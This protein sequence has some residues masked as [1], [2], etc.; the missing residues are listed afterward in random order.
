MVTD[1]TVPPVLT[2]SVP[3][4]NSEPV[5]SKLFKAF[6]N[7]ILPSGVKAIASLSSSSSSTL[8][9]IKVVSVGNVSGFLK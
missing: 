1:I 3:L 7:V 8:I 9:P 6:S 5:P 2:N 4:Y